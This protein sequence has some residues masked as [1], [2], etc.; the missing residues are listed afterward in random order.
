MAST[1]KVFTIKVNG[2]DQAINSV[3]ELEDSIKGLES[4]LKSAEFGSDNFKQLKQELIVARTN[5]EEFN[6]SSEAVKKG[7]IADGFLKMGEAAAGAVGLISTALVS[8]GASS[9]DIEKV[10]AKM[11]TVTAALGSV[12]VITEALNAENRKSIKVAFDS[13]KAYVSAALARTR[14]ALAAKAA[15]LATE[16]AS[17]ASL[18]AGRAITFLQN[19]LKTGPLLIIAGVVAAAAAAFA[20]FQ[21]NSRDAVEAVNKT[22][23]D[24]IDGVATLLEGERKKAAVQEANSKQEIARKKAEGASATELANLEAKF[25]RERNAQAEVIAQLSKQRI[26]DGPNVIA[27]LVAERKA[28]EKEIENLNKKKDV[29]DQIAVQ[30]RIINEKTL[31]ISHETA[32]QTALEKELSN[33]L[34]ERIDIKTSEI[35]AETN[36]REQQEA[37]AKEAKAKADAEKAALKSLEDQIAA[38]LEL[39]KTGLGI[40]E[41]ESNIAKIEEALGDLDQTTIEGLQSASILQRQLLDERVKLLDDAAVVAKKAEEKITTDLIAQLDARRKEGHLSNE[42]YAKEFEDINKA[43]ANNQET[44]QNKLNDD[45]KKSNDDYNK[46]VKDNTDAEVKI[47]EDGAAKQLDLEKAKLEGVKNANDRIVDDEKKTSVERI[48]AV[49]RSGQAQ[50][51]IINKDAEQQLIGLKKDSVEYKTVIQNRDNAIIEQTQ[52]TADKITEIEDAAKAARIAAAVKLANQI[53]EAIG[54]AVQIA[55]Q[56][57]SAIAAENDARIEESKERIAELD[58]IQSDLISKQNGLEDEL[59]TAR[60]QRAEDLLSQIDAARAAREA[61]AKQEQAQNA[62]LAAQEEKKARLAKASAIATAIQTTVQAGLAVATA[63][64][65][66][67]GTPIVGVIA[68]LA[69]VASLIGSIAAIKSAAKFEKGGLVEGKLHKD[70]GTMIEAEHGEFV[71]NRKATANNLSVLK[72][73]NSGGS[74]SLARKYENGG[75]VGIS[76]TTFNALNSNSNS[77]IS[78]RID[79]MNS[80]MVELANR[81]IYTAITDVNDGQK[82]FTKIKNSVSF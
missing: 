22:T 7:Q 53:G 48:D 2:V 37:A 77:N 41:I 62:I 18:G 24:A 57:I 27:Q 16:G 70:G 4:E 58:Q 78:M 12:K 56:I 30:Q 10:Q 65:A 6:V 42:E 26:L 38:R 51:D 44:I 74:K 19:S 29:V 17:K 35:A 50:I 32:F 52:A 54:E 31:A 3:N 49:K 61:A 72:E 11:Q 69:F 15:A 75:V 23:Q 71:V 64:T 67:A 45:K 76:D 47:K 39:S 28:A 34:S 80:A 8:F 46:S 59:Q 81:P 13:A 63:F 14:E 79:Q 40:S 5:M 21:K 66:N 43:S 33:T 20:L 25:A 1:T 73:I 68:A 55:Q 9:E 36:L 60:G 82:N